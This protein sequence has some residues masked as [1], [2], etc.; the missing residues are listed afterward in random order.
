M[1]ILFFLVGL[2]RWVQRER[3]I[4]D[5]HSF[6]MV[7]FSVRTRRHLNISY[8]MIRRKILKYVIMNFDFFTV[9]YLR[10]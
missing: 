4:E 5:G 7:E 9:E 3:E 2:T 10:S 6:V 8:S 1:I